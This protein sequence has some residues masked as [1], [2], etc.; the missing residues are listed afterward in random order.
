MIDIRT[1]ILSRIYG[2]C[3]K[4]L[5]PNISATEFN[6]MKTDFPISQYVSYN[7]NQDGISISSNEGKVITESRVMNEVW[8]ADIDVLGLG[9]HAQS[10]GVED[11]LE[12]PALILDFCNNERMEPNPGQAVP[13]NMCK[14]GFMTII[15]ST[16]KGD[17][18]RKPFNE[19]NAIKVNKLRESLDY[20]LDPSYFRLY[21]NTQTGEDNVIIK[22]N[23]PGYDIPSKIIDCYIMS[24]KNYGAVADKYITDFL[25]VVE[26]WQQKERGQ[27]SV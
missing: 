17:R 9:Q 6:N 5:T 4:L 2:Q 23:R 27:Y 21:G 13:Q 10:K 26:F 22:T 11:L 24:T 16:L 19:T 18:G 14:E 12:P 7:L 1:H 20:L 3:L 8:I 25:F 15:R